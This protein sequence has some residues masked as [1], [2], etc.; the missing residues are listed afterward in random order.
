MESDSSMIMDWLIQQKP[1]EGTIGRLESK[2]GE[3]GFSISLDSLLG[4]FEGECSLKSREI[5]KNT[6]H[7]K[8]KYGWYNSQ[9]RDASRT[10]SFK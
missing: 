9:Q 5:G 4:S 1:S 2:I 3:A 6:A 8:E 7:Y 10:D